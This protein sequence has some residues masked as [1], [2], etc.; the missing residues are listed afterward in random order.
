MH[1][2]VL[3]AG[4][5][6]RLN[7]SFDL[8]KPLVE[9]HK[10]KL[11]DY[12]FDF[13]SPGLFEKI[14]VVGGYQYDALEAY[15]SEH[16]RHDVQLV[17]NKE[18]QKGSI[19]SVLEALEHSGEKSFFLTNADHIFFP[20]QMS[21]FSQNFSGITLFCDTDRALCDDDM[22]IR[23]NQNQC[24]QHISK[25]L[26]EYDCGYIGLTYVDKSYLPLYR[27]AINHTLSSHGPTASVEMIIQTLA[28]YE[29][30]I[31][32]VS[33]HQ[34]LKWFEIDTLTDFRNA[35]LGVPE[36]L[37]TLKTNVVF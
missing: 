14:I 8:T 4:K 20:E 3:A 9:L 28:N 1:S 32:K 31:P 24:V 36:I 35:E 26:H 12:T 30:T 11:I 2:I 13:L 21:L 18:Y 22:K 15:L 6:S 23:L 37:P 34:N 33:L 25:T 19:L 5:G 10:K 27:K 29:P 7:P 17:R 16:S